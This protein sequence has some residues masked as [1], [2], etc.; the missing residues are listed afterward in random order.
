MEAFVTRLEIFTSTERT[1]I[2]LESEWNRYNPTGTGASISS[3]LQD[4]RVGYPGRLRSA[5]LTHF[6]PGFHA[7]A[8]ERL[9]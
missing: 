2:N 7:A 9:L 1:V 5:P 3:Y 4:V 6:L 8:V